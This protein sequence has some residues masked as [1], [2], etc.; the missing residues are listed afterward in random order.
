MFKIGD[1]V[2]CVDSEYVLN[3]V[4]VSG[5]TYTINSVREDGVMLEELPT[6]GFWLSDRFILHSPL[7]MELL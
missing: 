2:V 4:L 3:D 5:A 6:I 1:K 7:I